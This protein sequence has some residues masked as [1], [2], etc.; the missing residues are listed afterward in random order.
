MGVPGPVAPHTSPASSPSGLRASSRRRRKKARAAGFGS[1]PR[2]L[3][4]AVSLAYIVRQN[5]T[6]AYQGETEAERERQRETQRERRERERE[7]ERGRRKR[8]REEK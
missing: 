1:G 8:V 4:P 2:A 7:R 5:R 6:E 3:G